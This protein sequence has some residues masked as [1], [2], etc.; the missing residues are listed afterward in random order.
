MYAL[1]QTVAPTTAAADRETVKRYLGLRH[2]YDNDLIDVLISAATQRI[3]DRTNRQLITATWQ[4]TLDAFPSG[5]IVL[6]KAPCQSVTLFTYL[7]DDDDPNNVTGYELN[8]DK[9]PSELYLLNDAYWPNDIRSEPNSVS[10]TFTAGYGDAATDIP[11]EL[12]VALF[13]AVKGYYDL[14]DEIVSGS[15][16]DVPHTVESIIESFSF[17]DE[18]TSYG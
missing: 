5:C 18:F 2:N 6:P 4:L 8:T 9:E 15:V 17:G 14:R 12:Q 11:E 7:D 16:N 1:K 3:E 10:I 13:Q